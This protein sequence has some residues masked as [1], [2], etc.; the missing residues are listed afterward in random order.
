[1]IDNATLLDMIRASTA[2]VITDSGDIREHAQLCEHSND[3]RFDSAAP[4]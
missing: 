3:C 4:F 2:I 1:M